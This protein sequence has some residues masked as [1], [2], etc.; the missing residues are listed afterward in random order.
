MSGHRFFVPPE[1]ISSQGVTF[2]KEQLHQLEHVLRLRKGERVRVFDGVQPL[3]LLVELSGAIVGSCPQPL[4]PR[5]RLIAYPS[6]LQRDKFEIVLQKLTELGVHAIV[7]VLTAR[8]LVRSAPDAARMARWRS[9]IVEAAEQCGRGHVP[10]LLEALPLDRAV[11]QAL[12]GGC[13][14]LAYEGERRG[15]LKQA[16]QEC[17]ETVCILVGPE[18]GY[19][20][21]EAQNAQAAGVKLVTLG[22]RILRTETASLV[23]AALVLYERGDLSSG[24]Q[25]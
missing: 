12:A 17:G 11:E 10:P 8:G 18:G 6:L 21:E 19:T 5:T 13:A 2:S 25:P 16:L 1:D 4:E 9:I 3:D 15:T 7:P 23:L 20:T 24:Q 22:P 14:I